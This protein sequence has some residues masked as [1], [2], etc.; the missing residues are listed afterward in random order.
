ML[1]FVDFVQRMEIRY[2]KPM[3]NCGYWIMDIDKSLDSNWTNDN[4]N[5]PQ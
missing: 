2:N 3:R 5:D 4:I 1:D